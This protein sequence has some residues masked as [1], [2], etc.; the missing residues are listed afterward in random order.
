MK[1]LL[2]S[3]L[4]GGCFTG[5]VQERYV[6]LLGGAEVELKS[7]V[8]QANNTCSMVDYRMMKKAD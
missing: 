2:L 6:K 5:F 1:K 8:K 4:L 7:A 3:I